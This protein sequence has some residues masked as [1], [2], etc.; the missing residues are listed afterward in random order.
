[1]I[2]D[3]VVATVLWGLLVLAGGLAMFFAVMYFSASAP[4]CAAGSPCAAREQ[5]EF[6]VVVLSAGV[7]G[8]WAVAG[9]GSVACAVVRRSV[10]YWP[11]L[12]IL[13]ASAGTWW[14]FRLVIDA[15]GL[16]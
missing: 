12:G 15:G 13:I 9:V 14:G 3:L 10:W 4:G 1:M 11:L 5:A 2:A 6:A 8:G 7:L 16:R